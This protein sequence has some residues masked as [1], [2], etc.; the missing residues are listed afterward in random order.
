MN[1]GL[2]VIKMLDLIQR[3]CF[4]YQNDEMTVV[5]N[6]RSLQTL[7]SMKQQKGEPMTDFSN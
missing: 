1:Q 5:S 6:Y 2:D 7:Y 4:N 3:V